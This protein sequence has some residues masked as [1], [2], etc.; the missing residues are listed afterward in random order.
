MTPAHAEADVGRRGSEADG[1]CG[2]LACCVWKASP[3]RGS[4]TRRLGRRGDCG[5]D[6][7]GGIVS[8]GANEPELPGPERMEDGVDGREGTPLAAKGSAVA[9]DELFRGEGVGGTSIVPLLPALLAPAFSNAGLAGEETGGR[10]VSGI[11]G[12]GAEFGSGLEDEE[13]VGR[14]V[15]GTE[16]RGEGDGGTFVVGIG[17]CG[18]E[19]RPCC[20]K[21][22]CGPGCTLLP[23]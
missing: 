21:G 16:G 23:L 6:L 7:S 17:P 1:C 14:G 18:A 19:V 3:A 4:V 10:A 11:E 9:G 20:R 22:V 5:R 8:I 13:L 15:A 12:A 2:C